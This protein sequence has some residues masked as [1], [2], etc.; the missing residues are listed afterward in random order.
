MKASL[1]SAASASSRELLRI[2]RTVLGC[3]RPPLGV[4]TPRAVSSPAICLNV[5][6]LARA[7]STKLRTVR[8][9]STGRPRRVPRALAALIPSFVRVVINRRPHRATPPNISSL[10]VRRSRPSAATSKVQ[11]CRRLR[12]TISAH[13]S[14]LR[15]TRSNVATTSASAA[16]AARASSAGPSPAR[17]D[18]GSAALTSRSVTSAASSQPRSA[19]AAHTVSSCSSIP[20]PGSACSSAEKRAYAKARTATVPHSKPESTGAVRRRGL[21]RPRER[22]PDVGECRW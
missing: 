16:P 3:Q 2:D 22:P 4:A 9:C 19:M 11:P 5:A 7:L 20:A 1:V 14:G 17:L 13:A 21:A 15:V 6:P 10:S 12:S 8:E 18:G